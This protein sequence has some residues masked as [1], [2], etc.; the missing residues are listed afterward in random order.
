[1]QLAVTAIAGKE[2]YTVPDTEQML[3]KSYLSQQ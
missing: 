1:M 3:Q 2:L